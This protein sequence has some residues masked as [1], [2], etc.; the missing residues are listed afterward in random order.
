MG[1]GGGLPAKSELRSAP[2]RSGGTRG[3]PEKRDRIRLGSKGFVRR[4]AYI[5]LL[6]WRNSP[7]VHSYHMAEK[8]KKAGT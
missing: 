3:A 6:H 1:D 5:T 7:H 2:N 8:I 4:M